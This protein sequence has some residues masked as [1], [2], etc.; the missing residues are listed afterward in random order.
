MEYMLKKILPLAL[1]LSAGAA[2]AKSDC[3][4]DC[5]NTMSTVTNYF[6]PR[7]QGRDMVKKN[8]G[9][10]PDHRFLFDMDNIYGE[11]DIGVEYTQSFSGHKIGKCLFGPAINNNLSTS[12]SSAS[13]SCNSDCDDSVTI[14]IVGSGLS[15]NNTSDLIADNFFLPP[16]FGSTLTIKPR[17]SNI[18]MPMH[19]YIALD[20]CKRGFY[21]RGWAPLT[22]TRWKLNAT[23]N[24]FS[25]GNTS[26]F[27]AGDVSPEQVNATSLYSSFLSYT[28]GNGIS[29]PTSTPSVTVQSLSAQKICSGCDS[30][31]K[32]GLADLRAE[33]G[34]NFLLDEDYHLGLNIQVAA[35]TG[36]DG[37]DGCDLLFA[38]IV[39]NGK[40]WE[41][42]GGITG[43]YTFWRSED[44]EQ[45]FGFY[46]DADIT[47]MFKHSETRVF[48]LVGKPL[49]RYMYAQQMGPVTSGLIVGTAAP[50]F[51]FANVW[52]PVANFAQQNVDTSFDVQGDVAAKFVYTCRGFSWELGYDFWGRSC[53]KV[54]VSC[55]N[56][57]NTTGFNNSSVTWALTGGQPVYGFAGQPTTAYPISV[58]GSN[59]SVFAQGTKDNAQNIVT[60]NGQT[61]TQNNQNVEGSNPGVVITASDLDL[62]SGNTR[63]ISHKVF[64]HFNYTWIECEDWIPFI[65]LGASGEFASNKSRSSNNSVSSTNNCNNSCDSCS[66]CGLSQWAVWFKLGLSFN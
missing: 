65:G 46:I 31:T 38:P 30:V 11:F 6:L 19:L 7:S 43:H 52:A 37:N 49:S 9:L 56:E 12:V 39:G 21:V 4:N 61:L 47:H 8:A 48:D 63:G 44:E 57:C 66:D 59:A 58:T 33:L 36:N 20:E 28:C 16:D 25:Q 64:T 54:E 10:D 14:R 35:P 27:A 50:N 15:P 3:S 22:N 24:V 13:T 60:F 26:G 41:L 55:D 32:T 23:E 62:T 18:N 34:W 51:Q 2:I 17:I 40:H 53:E 42:G 5:N 29:L 1:L 45:E